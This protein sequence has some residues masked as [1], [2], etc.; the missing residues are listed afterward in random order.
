MM[1]ARTRVRTIRL[2]RSMRMKRA[3]RC[4]GNPHT[5]LARPTYRLALPHDLTRR[6]GRITPSSPTP[7][8]PRVGPPRLVRCENPT[9]ALS[10]SDI[11][12]G[13]RGLQACSPLIRG[14]VGARWRFGS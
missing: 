5:L 13:Y 4:A 11:L 9:A 7:L 12:F 6:T 1:E 10:D 14:I 3:A 2:R 8:L